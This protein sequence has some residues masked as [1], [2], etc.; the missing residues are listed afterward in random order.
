MVAVLNRSETTQDHELMVDDTKMRET[1]VLDHLIREGEENPYQTTLVH[2]RWIGDDYYKVE[3]ITEGGKVTGR[4]VDTSLKEDR[5]EA[6]QQEWEAKWKPGLGEEVE[7]QSQNPAGRSLLIVPIVL[8]AKGCG[9]NFG[10][11]RCNER[12]C[13]CKEKGC[14]CHPCSKQ[15]A[16]PRR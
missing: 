5:V 9:C 12:L 4:N 11:C 15:R 16:K 8:S 1:K 7:A 6:F 2:T 13:E 10:S 14:I 3:E